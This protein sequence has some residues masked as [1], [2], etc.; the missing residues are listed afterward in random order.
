VATTGGGSGTSGGTSG[1]TPGGTSNPGGT[2]TPDTT[3]TTVPQLQGRYRV[4]ITGF[5]VGSQTYDHLLGIDGK[6]DE[7][8]LA[9]HVLQ[10]DTASTSLVVANKV[11]TSQVFGDIG[12]F[13]Y[14]IKAGT[15]G[16]LG[17]LVTGNVFPPPKGL[18]GTG[19]FP[20][21]LWEGA[22]TQGRSAVMIVPT[23]WEWDNN[24]E[25]FGNWVT[26]RHSFLTRLL[27]P[28]RVAMILLN[29]SL[30]PVEMGSPGLYVHTNMYADPRDRPIGLKPAV[31]TPGAGF[32]APLEQ[33]YG[34]KYGTML[35]SVTT[36]ILPSNP[37]ASFARSLLAQLLGL[38]DRFAPS[39]GTTNAVIP[40]PS[41]QT[42]PT[43]LAQLVGT[44]RSQLP[45]AMA[46]AISTATQNIRQLAGMIQSAT[47]AS[48]SSNLYLFEK[49]VGVTPAAVQAALG[50][51]KTTGAVSIDV[52][53]VDYSSLQGKYTL[54]LKVERLQ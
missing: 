30:D 50:A 52:S 29:Q 49:A 42:A 20:L 47:Q 46:S 2:T 45:N 14:R 37:L 1:P 40:Q 15:A 33:V 26:G 13:S 11:Q 19:G 39:L 44:L 22:L 25:L 17:G 28:D 23:V 36:A 32:F 35:D 31:P 24:P 9:T 10:F 12:G 48:F 43:P 16:L 41:A 18:V 38:L 7:V 3:K 6:G 54:H 53:Y 8:W 21:V 27:Q 51:G 34:A 4:S 5:T